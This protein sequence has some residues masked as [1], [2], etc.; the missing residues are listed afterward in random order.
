MSLEAFFFYLNPL[1]DLLSQ[2]LSLWFHPGLDGDSLSA[3]S[4]S[5]L[6][7]G[8]Q[9]P[10]MLPFVNTGQYLHCLQARPG[11]SKH[12]PHL[13]LNLSSRSGLDSIRM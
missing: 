4:H 9:T 7:L 6:A 10:Q 3:I 5:G 8:R 11:F 1:F 13:E 12:Q 2:P